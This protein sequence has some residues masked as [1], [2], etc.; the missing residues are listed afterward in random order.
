MAHDRVGTVTRMGGAARPD[1]SAGG[2]PDWRSERLRNG[3]F[4]RVP[5]AGADG[6][7]WL[8]GKH[9]V[10][11]DPEQALDRTG[12]AVLVCL[13]EAHELGDRYPDYVAWLRSAGPR[14]RW[15]PVPDLGA[16][17]VELATAWATAVSADL[18]AGRSVLV[19]CGAGMGRAGTLA[20]AVLIVR[21][22]TVD[23]AVAV[24][25]AARPGAGPE[26][27]A[28]SDLLARIAEGSSRPS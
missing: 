2:R 25:A 20:A 19:H 21:G 8:A 5:V 13:N 7:L 11:P 26:A 18:D 1:S 17:A 23:E 16:P 9:F 12:A 14:A 6:G 27:G 10:G 15:N 28:Q 3:G 22:L 4:D 24:V